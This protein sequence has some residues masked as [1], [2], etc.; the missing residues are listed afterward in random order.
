MTQTEEIKTKIGTKSKKVRSI[1]LKIIGAI[2]IAIVLF[3]AIVYTVNIISS[4]SEQK[5]IESYGQHVS[6]D[7]KNMNVLIQGEGEETIVLLPGFGTAAP[8]LD[9]LAEDLRQA[10]LSLS[11]ITGQFTADDLLGEIFS[12]FCIGK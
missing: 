9:L 5:R 1:L 4:N 2:V 11:D 12:R 8:A 6:V 7:G 3:L 10:Q